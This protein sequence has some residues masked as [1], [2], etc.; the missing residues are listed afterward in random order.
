MPILIDELLVEAEPPR[1]PAP[2][3]AGAPA[4]PQKQPGQ[5][6][7]MLEL[8]MVADRHDRIQAD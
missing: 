8:S 6:D 3:A 5:A 1:S 2:P 4:A 7:R